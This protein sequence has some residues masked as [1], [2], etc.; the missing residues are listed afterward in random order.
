MK[1]LLS[2]LMCLII[3]LSGCAKTPLPSDDAEQ[4]PN[5][6]ENETVSDDAEQIPNESE[7][8]TVSDD[9]EQIPNEPEKE[10]VSDEPAL[11]PEPEP[12]PESEINETPQVQQLTLPPATESMTY[13]DKDAYVVGFTDDLMVLRPQGFTYE[14][15]IVI[16]IDTT[17]MDLVKNEKVYITGTAEPLKTP[18]PFPNDTGKYPIRFTMDKSCIVSRQFDTERINAWE[19]IVYKEK[20]FVVFYFAKRYI[21]VYCDADKH[22]V[23]D[24]AKFSGKAE[25]I[26]PQ[27]ITLADGKEKTVNY[28]LTN[29]KVTASDEITVKKPVIYLYP[30]TATDVT[31]DLDFDGNLTCTYPEYNGLWQVNAAPDGTLTDK[32]GREYY[33]LY[34]EGESNSSYVSDKKVGFMVKGEDTAEF[35]REKV[36]A[37]GLDQK[38]ANEFIIYWLPLMQDNAYNYIYFSIDEYCDAAKLNVTPAP[39]TVIRFSMVWQGLDSPYAVTEQILPKTPVRRGFTVVEWGGLEIK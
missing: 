34:W 8:E 38:E 27:T 25:K 21:K 24:F 14:S 20:D 7:K 22:C 29:A 30:E 12:Q 36:L 23:G 17:E 2:L 4:I 32:S 28:E 1:K 33:C 11:D 9:A 15:Y 16:E 39:D 31:V 35:L 13:N 6:P 3:V 10:T 5:E 19:E 26:K 18:M 37:L